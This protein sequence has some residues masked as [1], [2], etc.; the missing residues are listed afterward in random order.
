M[1]KKIKKLRKGKTIDVCLKIT[2]LQIPDRPI[3]NHS[4][5]SS[6]QLYYSGIAYMVLMTFQVIPG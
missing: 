1:L 2:Q 6:R 5:H 4:L 3:R